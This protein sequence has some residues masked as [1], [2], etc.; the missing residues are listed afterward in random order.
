MSK[1]LIYAHR[2]ASNLAPENTMPA[3]QL[4]CESGAEGIEIDVQL[5]KDR[6]PVIIHDENVRRTTNGTG[7]VQEYTC[8]QIKKLDAGSWY[9][10]KF[11]DC[12][13]VT[14]DEF[15]CWFKTLPML[16]N[17]ELKTN[18]IEY[19]GIERLVYDA[20]QSHQM[21][22]RTVISSFN[23]NS[24]K[25][26]NEIDP[27]VQTA[28]LTSKKR[29]NLVKFAKKLGTTSLH[30]RYRLLDKK[31]VKDCHKNKLSLRVYTINRPADMN[32]C[33]KLK[34]DAIFTD[35]PYEA[36]EYRTQIQKSEKE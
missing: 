23:F 14:L 22:D 32:R 1:T 24:I 25:T 15:L 33:F 5:T 36:V 8:E 12:S 7:L 4:A 27:H 6:V 30:V 2:G 9:S 3:F 17:L 21:L 31:L 16:L 34:C 18:V 19:K 20:L 29:H 10:T 28:F 11:S 35:C 26:I 13:I